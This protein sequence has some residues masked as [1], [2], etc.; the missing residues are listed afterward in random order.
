MSDIRDRIKE[1]VREARHNP[2]RADHGMYSH[3][4]YADRILALLTD[5]QEPVA[6]RVERT[7]MVTGNYRKAVE[8]AEWYND[9]PRSLSPDHERNAVVTPLY[10]HPATD[11]RKDD[12]GVGWRTTLREGDPNR[13][14]DRR[15][16]DE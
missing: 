12:V 16:N 6:W 14:S 9:G 11:R 15:Q 13:L 5:G 7:G 4:W 8:E 1:I 2:Y 10:A 3:E